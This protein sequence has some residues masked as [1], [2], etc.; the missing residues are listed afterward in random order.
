MQLKDIMPPPMQLW[1]YFVGATKLRTHRFFAADFK[2]ISKQTKAARVLWSGVIA[3]RLQATHSIATTIIGSRLCGSVSVLTSSV[4]D[5]RRTLSISSQSSIDSDA[6]LE[7]SAG[8]VAILSNKPVT[9][10][11][12]ANA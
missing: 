6:R 9:L 2:I 3:S 7:R 10:K 5:R 12:K 1:Q 8:I 11:Y 4:D